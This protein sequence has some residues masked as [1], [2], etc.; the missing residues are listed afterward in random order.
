MP[1]CARRR[2]E[3]VFTMREG[4]FPPM[5]DLIV[6]LNL[7]NAS[8]RVVAKKLRAEGI[9]CKILPGDSTLSQILEQAPRGLILAGGES[10]VAPAQVDPAIFSAGYPM[11]ALGDGAAAL[12]AALEGTMGERLLYGAVLPVEYAPHPLTRGMENGERL[13]Q[14][15]KEMFLSGALLPL[16]RSHEIVLGFA[17]ESRPLFGIQFQLEQNDPDASLLLRNFATVYCGCTQWW[18]ED[19]FIDRAIAE[20]RKTVGEGCATCAMTGG[21]D[22][23]VS[24]VLAFRALGDR[25]KCIFV[26]TGL[27]REREADDFM[28]FYRDT[29]GMNVTRIDAD[30]RFL[31]ALQGVTDPAEKKYRI[32]T[33]MQQVLSEGRS[34][35]GDYQALISGTSYNDIMFGTGDRRPQLSDRVP[36]IEPVRE[37]FKSEIRIV[38]D[39]LSLPSDIISRQ[40]FPGSGLALRIL[41][42]VTAARLDTLRAADAIFRSEIARA[43]QA[44]R[45]WQYFAVLSPLPEQE[46]KSIIALRAV[47]SGEGKASYAARLSFDVLEGVTDRILRTCPAV[48]RV[49]YDMTPVDE[50]YGVEWQ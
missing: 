37:L 29:L 32:G 7:D 39:L 25:L 5:Q 6:V 50:T 22:S 23:G 26:D 4:E 15:G 18:C 33:T 14:C 21:L 49:V 46:E 35:L 24:A 41:G 40:P 12:L 17:H 1:F 16:C 13:V 2:N 45:L 9:A 31:A 10:G 38:G 42:E 27:L 43:N 30:D 8:G 47:Q 36:V 48:S 11:L 44:R 3:R 28:A 34:A 19:A 20:I